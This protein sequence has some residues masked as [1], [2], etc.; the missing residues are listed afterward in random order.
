MGGVGSALGRP[1]IDYNLRDIF[2]FVSPDF[3][4]IGRPVETDAM[5]DDVAGVDLPLL[6]SR[7][8]W[9]HVVMHVGLSHL[10]RDAFA[11][12]RTKWDFIQESAVNSW[13]RDRPAFAYS[14]NC[15][16]QHA[17]PILLEKQLGFD[18]VIDTLQLGRMSF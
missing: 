10:H 12:G 7:E 2:L 9:L 6:D 15:L 18:D 11:E 14:L 17:G 4:K 16:P 8:Q 3:V 13:N 5:G 1:G